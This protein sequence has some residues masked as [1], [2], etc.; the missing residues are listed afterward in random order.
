M[1]LSRLW[2]DTQVQ[3]NPLRVK[4]STSAPVTSVDRHTRTKQKRGGGVSSVYLWTLV[5][6]NRESTEPQSES[7]KRR[8]TQ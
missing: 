5:D 7:N 2:T 1:H 3:N 4:E 8:K 6:S